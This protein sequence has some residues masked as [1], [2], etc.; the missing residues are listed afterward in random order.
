MILAVVP[1]VEGTSGGLGTDEMLRG[2]EE[3]IESVRSA[4]RS[5]TPG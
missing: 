2:A 4:R 3:P 1:A 5:G